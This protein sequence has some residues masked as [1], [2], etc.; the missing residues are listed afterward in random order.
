[1]NASYIVTIQTAV[2]IFF[3]PIFGFAIT[4]IQNPNNILLFALAALLLVGSLFLNWFI[5]IINARMASIDCIQYFARNCFCFL[6][7]IANR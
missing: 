1:M 3:R 2:E 5:E 4:K 7:W 6:W